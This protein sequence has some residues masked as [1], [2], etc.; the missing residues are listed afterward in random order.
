M[1]PKRWDKVER[2]FN[3]VLE[4]EESRRA[5]ILDNSCAGDESLRKE[6]ESLLAHH[7]HD[8]SFIETPA[9]EAEGEL[10]FG[11]SG[12]S[13]S[14]SGKPNLAG[15]V[16]EQYCVLE[17]IGAGGMGVVY[18][19]EDTKLG[20]LVALKFLPREAATDRL[21]L[22]RF[23]RE[24]RATSA[25]NHPNICTIYDI[26]EYQGGQFIAMELLEGKTLHNRISGKPLPTNV[27]L[28]LAV[29]IADALDAAHSQGIIHRD[30][31][32][33]NI[34][35]TGRDQAKILD[36]GLAKKILGKVAVRSTALVTAS[37]TDEELTSEG[38]ALGTISYMSPEQ[39]RAEELDSRTDL[40]SL[41]AVLYEMVTGRP[42]FTGNSSAVIFEAILNKTP[43]PAQRLNPEVQEKLVEII[44][45]ALEKDRKLRYQSAAEVRAD[46]MRLRRDSESRR[47]RVGVLIERP[48]LRKRIFF[49]ALIIF[50][51]AV[52][53]GAFYH[54][55]RRGVATS[56]GWQQLTFFADSAI[57]P[58]LSPDGH[59]LAFIRG[60]DTLFGPGDV[61]LKLLPDGEPVQLTHD[62]RWKMSPTFSHDGS[63]IAY[64]TF[65]P[66]DT[67]EVPVLG[68]EPRVL[69]PN[70]SSLTWIQDGERVLFSEIKQG[71]HMAVV[72]SDEA[73]GHGR[74]V[75]IPADQRSM[76]HH[77][78]L[79]PDGKWV[80]VVE[81][82][83]QG[84]LGPC[85]VVPFE[86]NSNLRVVGPPDA[87]C[88]SGAWSP[89]GKWL[90]VSS[91]KGGKFHIWRQRFPDGTPEQV[92]SGP[93]E[94]EGIA[95]ASD[96]K[97]LVTSAGIQD[98]TVW[99]HDLQGEHQ[100]SSEGNAGVL[101]FSPDAR[102]L[103][104]LLSYRQNASAELW[105]AD[106]ASAK[107]KP[108][109]SGYS[110]QACGVGLQH[111][112]VSRD[113]KAIAF[114]MLDKTGHPQL[115]IAPT[116]RR[117]TPR[118]IESNASGDC[119]YFLPDGDVIFRAVEGG[120]NFLYRMKRDGTER[121][122][123]SGRAIFD[124][125]GVSADG[126]W[127]LAQTRGPD[128]EHPYFV[129]A[130]P[131]D[132]GPAVTVCLALCWATWDRTGDSLYVG[133]PNAGD[134]N[135]YSLPLQRTGLP[136]LPSSGISGKDDLKRMKASIVPPGVV[137]SAGTSSLYAYT[138]G[139]VQRNLYR[140][141]LP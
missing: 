12:A 49:V 90:Y 37:L 29:Q 91:N 126:R 71:L 82:N 94:E 114:S 30:I 101:Q 130:Y 103:Y 117:S 120:S 86:G 141:P 1:D 106:L 18:K 80:L 70:A 104:Y 59:M 92:T 54:F 68:G 65:D 115:W 39:A 139:N 140:I 63:R 99:V 98:S 52:V 138:R 31:K 102:Q 125:Y 44:D 122:K 62:K 128:A 124:P 16:I 110:L 66:W 136:A 133:L 87:T 135:T 19:A 15:A 131:I 6:I 38:A 48:V 21:A 58:A 93:T 64:G 118:L 79:S 33:G 32:P 5:S 2:I 23:W 77:S 51:A 116:D 78:Y 57:Y 46:L 10:G 95:I 56:A 60:E 109:L 97:S 83:R 69:L 74:D 96:G 50:L 28:D 20:R 34:F 24:A 105:V 81:M 41:G 73:R 36:F 47:P 129:A 45:K 55:A 113:G 14:A 26:E 121:R 8:G 7:H 40:F 67:W 11:A 75:Y 108:V 132:G 123:I 134:N 127:I 3:D 13:G 111:Y 17:E 43:V 85:R 72:T 89:D 4:A 84:E 27:L 76:A 137:E 42:P 112:A 53:G 100:I 25:L 119:P 35:V 107:S 88:T 22:A 9:F 61:Y